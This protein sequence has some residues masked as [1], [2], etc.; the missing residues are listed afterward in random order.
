M[1]TS[2][3]KGG[4]GGSHLLTITDKGGGV[5]TPPHMADIICEQSL[6]FDWAPK[7]IQ[8][9]FQFIEQKCVQ[10][11]ETKVGADACKASSEVMAVYCGGLAT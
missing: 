7:L 3:T 5:Q 1:L 10:H 8:K 2:L 11:C 6:S 9:I 4:G